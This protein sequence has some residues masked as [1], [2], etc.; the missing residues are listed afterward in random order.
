MKGLRTLTIEFDGPFF[1]IGNYLSKPSLLDS[2]HINHLR[3]KRM[4]HLSKFFKEG[5]THKSKKTLIT[6]YG[7]NFDT[8]LSG[9][10][11]F[12][13]EFLTN[14]KPVDSEFKKH[15]DNFEITH[16]SIPKIETLSFGKEDIKYTKH[17]ARERFKFTI[18]D[19]VHNSSMTISAEKIYFA[20]KNELVLGKFLAQ[21][22]TL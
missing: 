14:L 9:L 8:F 1:L 19:K 10:N 16:Q 11:Q 22:V 18:L 7:L 5:W 4:F 21:H 2:V 20:E 17:D 15:A 6:V 3:A 12:P 13:E